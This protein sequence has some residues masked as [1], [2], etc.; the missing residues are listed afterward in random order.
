MRQSTFVI[1][2]GYGDAF[3]IMETYFKNLSPE[4]GT[5]EKLMQDLRALR[6]DTEELFR[7]SGGMLARKSKHKLLSAVDR[8]K[9]TCRELKE[10]AQSGAAIADD[11]IHQYPYSAVGIAF[12][13]GLLIG[14]VALR[15]G[16]RRGA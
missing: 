11:A 6:Y 10:Q 8:A 15:N 3:V 4:E 1:G 2:D 7:I 5:P 14:I 9:A 16:G 13:L 12:G